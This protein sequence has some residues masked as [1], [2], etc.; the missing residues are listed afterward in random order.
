MIYLSSDLHLNH[1]KSFIYEPRGFKNVYE[2]NFT[3]LDNFNKIIKPDDD[4]YLLGDTFLGDLDT[5]INLFN[6]LPGKI[7]LV[8]GNHC[9][10]ARKEAMSKCYNVVEICGYASVLRYHKWHF[11]LSHYPTCTINFDDYQKPLKQRTICLAG[12]THSKEKF[13]PC[14]SY[15]VAVDAHNCFP[16]SIDEIIDDFK[17]KKYSDINRF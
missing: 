17:I 7:H 16:V 2:M 3:I 11:Y 8:W 12:H 6:Q 10:D 13:E 5:G 4:L 9:T 1:N 15:N 14:G